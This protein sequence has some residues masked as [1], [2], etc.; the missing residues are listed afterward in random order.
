MSLRRERAVSLTAALA[1]G[2]VLFFAI[3]SAVARRVG[4]DLLLPMAQGAFLPWRLVRLAACLAAGFGLAATERGR[5]LRRR[6]DGLGQKNGGQWAISAAVTGLLFVWT[7]RVTVLSFIVT[8]DSVAIKA[9]ASI[10]EA[11]LEAGT[12]T[13]SNVLFCAMLSLLYRAAPNGYWYTIYH[14]GMQLLVLWLLGWCILQKTARRGWPALAGCFI[15]ALLTAGVF[16]YTFGAVTFTLT[17]AVT[18]TG[19]VA[20]VL[21]RDE[22]RTFAGR[23]ASDVC[24]AAL[25]LLCTLHRSACGDALL[26]FWGLA[27]GYQAV[28]ILLRRDRRWVRQAAGLLLAAAA[29]VALCDYVPD[30]APV[31]ADYNYRLSEAYRSRIEDYLIDQ[32][33]DEHFAAV[34]YPPELGPLLRYWYFMDERIT[35]ESFMELSDVYYASQEAETADTDAAETASPLARKADHAYTL[36]KQF[37]KLIRSDLVMQQLTFLALALLAWSLAALWLTGLRRWLEALTALCAVGGSLLLSLYLVESV[38]FPLRAF[39]VIAFPAVVTL[40]LMALAGPGGA[41]GGPGRRKC[42]GALWL[43]GA[44]AAGLLCCAGT[45]LIPHATQ[46]VT[47]ADVFG[48]QWAAE[49]YAHANPDV[50]IINNTYFLVLDPI[51]T[52][53]DYPDN[54][55]PWGT[56]GDLA[57][58]AEERLYADAFFRDDVQF[59]T[60]NPA[61]VPFLLQYLTLD[62]GPV[63]IVNTVRLNGGINIYDIDQV[64]PDQEDYTGWYEQNGLTYYFI[65]GQAVTG[66]QV[67]DG[68]RCTFAPAGAAS[69]Y[70]AQFDEDTL[71]YTTD[72]YSLVTEQDDP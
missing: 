28:R 61:S 54:L 51:H 65:D 56:C 68:E 9:I 34:G 42:A 52:A 38:Y 13:F 46:P 62:Y 2:L 49:D 39:Q 3:E 25:M 55:V 44:A 11:G 27:A 5:R 64:R 37:V 8:D 21:C 4:A 71:V 45:Y 69:R 66:E 67:I 7:L 47:R 33:T 40:L 57:K 15:H 36:M 10:P 50:T 12:H 72:A 16:G 29:T 58:P 6:L 20:L 30:L 22:R 63:Q 35:T 31:E 19:A 14:V 17:A 18:G 70:F 26:C 43:A 59:L 41:A 32:M 1:A 53:P 48:P 60:Q 24:S 23:A